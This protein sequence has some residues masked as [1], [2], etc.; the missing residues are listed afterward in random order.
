MKVTVVA[1]VEFDLSELPTC[2][3]ADTHAQNLALSVAECIQE[4]HV[5][6]VVS[7]AYTP[8]GLVH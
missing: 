7:R 2:L 5:C 4:I 1:V 8:A 3:D 6:E